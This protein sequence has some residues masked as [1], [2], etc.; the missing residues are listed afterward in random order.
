MWLLLRRQFALGWC[1]IFLFFENWG[2]EGMGTGRG[3]AK[4]FGFGFGLGKA[5]WCLDASLFRYLIWT[6]MC[7]W[8]ARQQVREPCWN[9]RPCL[10][11]PSLSVSPFPSSLI[12]P[13]CSHAPLRFGNPFPNTN[14]ATTLTG[15]RYFRFFKFLDCFSKAYEAFYSAGGLGGVLLVA[16][17]SCMGGYMML[18]SSTIVSSVSRQRSGGERWG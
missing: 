4:W 9:H 14:Q 8:C 1:F 11:V 3:R 15:R 12:I 18:E 17:W 13:S 10:P 6:W 5:W 16:K 7:N 2:W